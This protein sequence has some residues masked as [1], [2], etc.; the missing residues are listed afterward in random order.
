M[1]ACAEEWS[2]VMR[3][4]RQRGHELRRVLPDLRER[5]DRWLICL[6]LRCLH[7]QQ[8]L[9]R[10]VWLAAAAARHLR[11]RTPPH[12]TAHRNSSTGESRP[13]QRAAAG[14]SGAFALLT[15]PEWCERDMAAP[16]LRAALLRRSRL[17]VPPCLRSILSG[18]SSQRCAAAR[19]QPWPNPPTAMHATTPR[20]AA[21]NGR[22][23][24]GDEQT[25]AAEPQQR[26]EQRRAATAGAERLR[27]MNPPVSF[28]DVVAVCCAPVCPL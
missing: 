24:A 9:W 11:H 16:R 25:S 12:R 23:R 10:A 6:A 7:P 3:V 17:A 1:A 18:K 5:V 22:A 8:S 2:A 19:Q 15:L 27:Q 14:H 21:R 13:G 4:L 20:H 26:A 28:A